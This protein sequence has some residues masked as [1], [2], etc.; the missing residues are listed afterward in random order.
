MQY[1]VFH[2][3]FKDRVEN[4][5][6]QNISKLFITKLLRKIVVEIRATDR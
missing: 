2:L 1:Y 5:A 4:Y 6:L 3:I